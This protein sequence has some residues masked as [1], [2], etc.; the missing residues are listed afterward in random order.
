MNDKEDVHGDR[1]G[2][3]FFERVYSIKGDGVAVL[4]PERLHEEPVFINRIRRFRA[5]N[6]TK[7]GQKK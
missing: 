1:A 5:L 6:I 2:P 7:S 3:D 4:K